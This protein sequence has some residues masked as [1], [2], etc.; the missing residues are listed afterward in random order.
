MPTTEQTI[1][2]EPSK[3]P[4]RRYISR[5]KAQMRKNIEE[6]IGEH[7]ETI[8][9]KL[10]KQLLETAQQR[11]RLIRSS[12][13]MIA[14]A[15]KILG[16]EPEMEIVRF[17]RKH[18]TQRFGDNI[19]DDALLQQVIRFKKDVVLALESEADDDF[20]TNVI[21]FYARLSGKHVDCHAMIIKVVLFQESRL[22]KALIEENALREAWYSRRDDAK[23]KGQF[24]KAFKKSTNELERYW[25][26]LMSLANYE[27]SKKARA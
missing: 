19:S 10:T 23:A 25:K 5:K 26:F 9:E 24:D 16:Q 6:D 2:A 17:L 13:Q 7:W 22:C 20:S 12:P 11:G 3:K 27:V 14:V 18:D 15:E 4:P 8:E 21:D 1:G